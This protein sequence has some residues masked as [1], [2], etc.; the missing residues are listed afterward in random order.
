MSLYVDAFVLPLPK[1]KIEAYRQLAE[2]AAQVWIDHGALQY[3][4][5]IGEDM[6][7]SFGVPFPKMMQTA[8]EETV[9]FAWIVYPSREDRDRINAAAMADPRLNCD[10][11]AMPFDC[12]RMVYGGFQTL[13]EAEAR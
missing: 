3:R 7:V 12:Q 4:E 9:V 1:D 13:V 11:A 8:P 5:C 6:E 2:T 10:P